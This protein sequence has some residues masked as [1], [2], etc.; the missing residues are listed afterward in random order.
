MEKVRVEDGMVYIPTAFM[1]NDTFIRTKLSLQIFMCIYCFS[2]N[3]DESAV[4]TES[5]K[6]IAAFLQCHP[7]SVGKMINRFVE[8]GY[9]TVTYQ[10]KKRIIAV[11][12]D[13]HLRY[14][15]K[16]DRHNRLVNEEIEKGEQLCRKMNMNA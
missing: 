4:C 6:K 16:V 10:N 11:N 8:Q 1:I 15:D 9:F 3:H 14:K 7:R 12:P 13:Y 2:M 5:N